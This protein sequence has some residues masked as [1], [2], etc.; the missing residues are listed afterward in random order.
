MR[1]ITIIALAGC[2]ATGSHAQLITLS[3][4]AD[5]ETAIIGDTIAWTLTVT[6]VSVSEYFQAYDLNLHASDDS[7][8]DASPF[9][10]ALSPLVAPAPGTPS[11]ASILG[12]Y[13]GQSSLIDPLN[14]IVGSP[15]ELGTFTVTAT[16]PGTL[17]Y[18]LSDGG[19]LD[20]VDTLKLRNWCF[21]PAA[22]NGPP[23]ALLS[24]HVRIVPAPGSAIA[25]GIMLAHRRRRP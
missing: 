17:S 16:Q 21:C 4:D 6:G 22:H 14:L 1:G 5:R 3:I 11:G 25:L 15:V 8:A 12:L 18:T 24:D 20:T 23:H 19:L 13:G 2:G 10:T 7:L 9:Q